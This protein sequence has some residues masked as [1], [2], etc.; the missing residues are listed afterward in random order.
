[1]TNEQILKKAIGKAVKN[2]YDNILENLTIYVE[3]D[4]SI[5]GNDGEEYYDFHINEIIFSPDFAKALW[6]NKRMYYDGV[7]AD[8]IINNS[9]KGEY[10]QHRMLDEIQAGR[11]PLLYLEKFL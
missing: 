4:G 7:G 11:N 8:T 2:G 6:G 1:M 9:T 10:H 5:S 3:E